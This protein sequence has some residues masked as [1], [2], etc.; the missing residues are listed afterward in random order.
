[1]KKIIFIL[2]LI[3]GVNS[4]SAKL[5]G[6][7]TNEDLI[8]IGISQENIDKVA[9]IIDEANIKYKMRMLEKQ[10]IEIEIKKY[11]ILGT[12]SNIGQINKLIDRL[13]IIETELMKDRL[14]YQ[15]KVRKYITPEQYLRAKEKKLAEIK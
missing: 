12:E 6:T 15:I 11:I 7:L 8:A 2:L 9:K 3:S 10:S 13:G 1:M 14:K 4:F 5:I